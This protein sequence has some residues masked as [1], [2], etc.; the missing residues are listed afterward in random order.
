MGLGF[1]GSSSHGLD[2][3]LMIAKAMRQ[4]LLE[5]FRKDFARLIAGSGLYGHGS[6]EGES[7]DLMYP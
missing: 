6:R 4:E 2:M 1:S 3:L 7:G 5:N